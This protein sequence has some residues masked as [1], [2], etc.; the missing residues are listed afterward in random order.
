MYIYILLLFICIFCSH[1]KALRMHQHAPS[2]EFVQLA[3]SASEEH[4]LDVRLR[5]EFLF[6]GGG[7]ALK[8]KYP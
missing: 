2:V 3:R 1:K 5:I 4:T 8:K 7:V 6:P